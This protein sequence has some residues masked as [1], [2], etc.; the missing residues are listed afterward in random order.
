MARQYPRYRGAE[1]SKD[2][3]SIYSFSL[4]KWTGYIT[5]IPDTRLTKKVL[6]EVIKEG[7]R[8]QGGQTKRYKDSLKAS[9]KEL[10]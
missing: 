9:L 3:K 10:N 8:S 5:R 2:A 1:D 4:H 7:K 6:Y